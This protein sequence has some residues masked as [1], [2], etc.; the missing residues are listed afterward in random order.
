METSTLL[1]GQT[2][3]APVINS[4]VLLNHWQAHRRLTRRTIEAFPEV[5]LFSF[6]LGGMRTFAAMVKELI[7]IA[8]PGV[9]GAATNEWNALED[10]QAQQGTKEELL[11]RWDDIT[12]Q[13][14][15]YWPQI[16]AARFQETVVAFG[17]YEAPLYETILYF[18]DNEI[19]HRGQGFVYL[20]ALGIEPPAFWD[21]S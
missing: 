19:H 16:D 12:E 18:I 17:Q 14:N 6:T 2:G 8:G 20:R 5:G 3:N 10:H 7:V 15:F 9:K 11:K 13:V 4:G 1:S 21:R